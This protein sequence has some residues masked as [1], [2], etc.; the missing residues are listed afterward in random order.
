MK[1]RFL[2]ARSL[3]A[4]AAAASV[5]AG[6]WSKSVRWGDVFGFLALLFLSALPIV[7]RKRVDTQPTVEESTGFTFVFVTSLIV[8]AGSFLFWTTSC[9]SDTF[10]ASHF[11]ER[12]CERLIEAGA[13]GAPAVWVGLAAFAYRYYKA[14]WC[15]VL[16]GWSFALIWPLIVSLVILLMSFACWL[17]PDRCIAF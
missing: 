15:W 12:D 14:K 17:H 2:G 5:I 9:S 1:L 11:G 8:A 3:L 6:L 4:G 13:L 7:P 16:M 10:I